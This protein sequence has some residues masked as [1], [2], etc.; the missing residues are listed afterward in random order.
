MY[1]LGGTIVPLTL[2]VLKSNIET[3]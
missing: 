2:P 3:G 1:W